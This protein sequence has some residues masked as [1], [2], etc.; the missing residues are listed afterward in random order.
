VHLLN[1]QAVEADAGEPVDL[2]QTP[3]D[4][5]FLSTAETELAVLAEGHR[6]L[7]DRAPSLRLANLLKL[8]HPYSVDL[9]VERVA[10]HARIVVV[11]LLGGRAYW[12]YGVERLAAVARAR[13]IPLALL[14]GD[15]RADAD[16][17]DWSTAPPEMQRRLWLW[18]IHGGAANARHLVAYLAETLGQGAGP[19][20]EPEPLP[21]AG[22]LRDTTT[23]A[24]PNA[25]L[26]F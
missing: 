19:W 26:V 24:G 22:L 9:W 5:V 2:E 13:G 11:R 4:I 6:Q 17:A 23:A 8:Q 15:D 16:L 21:A 3:G 20:R 1:A 12:P 7:G 25:A 14:P 18:L 10:A